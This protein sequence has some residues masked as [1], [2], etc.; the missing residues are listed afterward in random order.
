MAAYG[1]G[2]AHRCLDIVDGED[3]RARFAGIREI[4]LPKIYS[5]LI[6]HDRSLNVNTVNITV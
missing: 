1:L 3:E 5:I 6:S 2:R 4:S